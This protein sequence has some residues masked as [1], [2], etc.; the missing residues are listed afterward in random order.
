MRAQLPPCLKDR[1]SCSFLAPHLILAPE[2]HTSSTAL[3][4]LA[5]ENT[6]VKSNTSQQ[7][8]GVS[9]S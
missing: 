3:Q 7:E 2:L 6:A 5:L 9:L 4:G 8:A 1:A